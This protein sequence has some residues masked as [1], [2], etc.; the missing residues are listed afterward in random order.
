MIYFFLPFIAL[1]LGLWVF[2]FFAPEKKEKF[3]IEYY[4]QTNKYF[5]KYGDKYLERIYPT[6]I[7][8]TQKLHLIEYAKSFDTKEAAE[9]FIE[10]FKEQQLKENVKTYN[11]E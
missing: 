4:P 7:V 11:Y 1:V 8:T 5:P 10:L 2:L 6:G 3:T 9:R